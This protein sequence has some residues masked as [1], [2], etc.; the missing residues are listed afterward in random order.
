M[1]NKMTIAFI[2]FD[3]YDDMWDDCIGLF[4]RFWPDCPY[5]VVFVNNEKDVNWTN[6]EVLHAGKTLSGARKFR[7]LLTLQERHTCVCFSK[8]S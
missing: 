7:W 2:G 1:D 5:R 4:Q 8:I 3:G 6:V